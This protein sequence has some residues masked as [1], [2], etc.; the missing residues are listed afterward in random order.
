M[1]DPIGLPARYLK[2][3]LLAALDLV[4]GDGIKL[5]EALVR[6]LSFFFC[7]DGYLRVA[8]K[9]RVVATSAT[10]PALA[11]AGSE[12]SAEPDEEGAEGGQ[13]GPDDPNLHFDAGPIGERY[14]V[15]WA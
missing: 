8:L 3:V 13:A 5:E 6:F 7:S 10:P 11:Y 1:N 15:I 4:Q 14:P 12:D 9:S 2:N